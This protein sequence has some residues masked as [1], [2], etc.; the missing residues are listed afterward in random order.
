MFLVF[1]AAL[2]VG[3][4]AAS[5]A[6]HPLP[7]L[8][9]AIMTV[10]GIGLAVVTGILIIITRLYVKTKADEALVRTGMSGMK[11]ILS[12]GC[13]VIPVIH[14]IKR[15]PLES[16]R[17][18]MSRVDK[19]ALITADKLR[20]D[21]E[22]QFYVRVQPKIE[23]IQAAAR[24]L[25]DK[26]QDSKM[27]AELVEDKLISVLRTIAATKTLEELN[28]D[29]NTFVAEVMKIVASDLMHNGLT[30]ESVTISRLDQTDPK[31]L[32]EENIFDAQ[33]RATIAKIVQEKKTECN[34][35]VQEGERARIEQNV[36]TKKATLELE[37][38]QAEA[39]AKQAAQI[40]VVQAAQSQ[41]AAQKKLEAEQAI[42]LTGVAKEKATEVALR[43]K[44]QAIEVAARTKESAIAAAEA[45]RAKAEQLRAEAQAE[46]EKAK[47]SVMTVTI[48]AEADREQQKQVIA[49][50]GAAD[51]QYVTKQRAADAEAY[52]LKVNAEG[53]KAAS[54]ADAL[55][56]TTKAD[57][58]STAAKKHAEG[59]QAAAMVPITVKKAEVDV[60]QRRVEV[61]QNEL[62]ARQEFGATAQQFEI[63]KL[64]IEK[65]AEVMIAS[66][67]ATATLVSKI[68][69]TV[70]GTH[71]DVANLLG[72]LKNGMGI[73]NN[74]EG[75]LG[76]AGPQTQ[77][78]AMSALTT[79]TGLVQGLSQ[80]LG[81]TTIPPTS[82]KPAG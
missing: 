68:T 48:V 19:D 16:L 79:L 1:A 6:N 59:L 38:S 71:E 43:D 77:G 46:A 29:R 55:A 14:E 62:K 15:V 5:Q 81:G 9:S 50:K 11:V 36:T 33:G 32:R 66:A 24:S 75:F 78:A 61:L 72:A 70:V 18:Q 56:I 51:S 28:S 2:I 35:L 39:V 76:A 8:T 30:L 47:Q 44:E 12:G 63:T 73:A 65:R 67:Q 53:R 17:L 41:E 60:E 45:D 54:E 42:A 80:R 40:A 22:A 64:E 25:G 4:I 34:K 10:A 37:R 49:A 26:L 74:A 31:S 27:V 58:E 69:G 13:I 23:D 21:I 52:G 82:D 20:A 7:G 3:P 57:A